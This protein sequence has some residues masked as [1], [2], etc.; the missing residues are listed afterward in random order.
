MIFNPN[1]QFFHQK[2]PLLAVS[3]NPKPSLRGVF[4]FWGLALTLLLTQPSPNLKPSP[5]QAG[6]FILW[7]LSLTLAMSLTLTLTL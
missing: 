2:V 5:G 4:R 7:G 6:V 1:V 3:P